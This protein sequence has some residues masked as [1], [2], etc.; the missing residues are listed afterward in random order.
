VKASDVPRQNPETA[1]RDIDG[2]T[3]VMDAETAE[4]HSFSDVGGRIWELTDGER[5]VAD[6]VAVITAE[7]EVEPA[8]AEADVIGFLDELQGKR[9]V[10]LP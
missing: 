10:F 1:A 8:R 3:F 4:L 6:I 2:M 5:T 9:L 7:Y